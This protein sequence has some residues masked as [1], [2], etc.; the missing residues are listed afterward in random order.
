MSTD[1]FGLLC[2]Y[3]FPYFSMFIELNIGGNIKI[4]ID[5]IC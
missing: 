5:I 1:S 3:L 2:N 4:I